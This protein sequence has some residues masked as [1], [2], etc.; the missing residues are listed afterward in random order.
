MIKVKRLSCPD[1]LKISVVPETDGEFETKDAIVF[2]SDSL[3]HHKTFKRIR[4][5]GT[6]RTEASYTT[7]A[8]KTIKERLLIMFNGK[9][10]YCE[11]NVNAT[12]FGDIEHFR[13]KGGY[14]EPLVQPGYY[15]LASEWENLLYSCAFCNQTY[16]HK[17]LVNGKIVE[18]I[19]GKL[20]QFPLDDERRRIKIEDG[21][22]YF[23]DSANYKIAFDKEESV[24]LLL[25][26]CIDNVE[27]HFKYIEEGVILAE[28]NLNTLDKKRADTSIKVYAL[29][30][31]GLVQ[32][33][34]QKII[35]IKAQIERIKEAIKNLN[36]HINNSNEE[37]IWF[38]GILRREMQ[39]LKS[40]KDAKQ[41]YAGLARY[42]INKHFIT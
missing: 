30:R 31:V 12:Y 18:I 28:D 40:F 16:T 10:A 27:D 42:F 3:N 34:E 22:K 32:A 33:R 39:I 5:N 20:N 25:N 4:K 26:P 15:W 11:S 37:R 7:Y 21:Q 29:Q 9:C 6:S 1:I 14:G 13:P 24:R 41:D 35:I 8:D 17:V 38:E 2:F 19:Q 23:S 36:D